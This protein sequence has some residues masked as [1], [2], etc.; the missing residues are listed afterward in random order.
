[1][2]EENTMMT[3]EGAAAEAAAEQAAKAAAGQSAEAAAEQAAEAAAG[4]PAAEAKEA[5]KADAPA[6]QTGAGQTA[7]LPGKF[8]SVDALV[9]AY[10]ALEA[11]FTR[12]S[13]RLRALEQ[14]KKAPPTE[15]PSPV[16]APCGAEQV[17]SEETV[18]N[19]PS[20]GR[21]AEKPFIPAKED[22]EEVRVP[23]MMHAG[24]GVTAPA[25]RPKNFEEAGRLALGYLK[26]ARKG[27]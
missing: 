9:Q 19:V 17:P 24:A 11:E 26:N 21:G 6:A 22:R 20:A 2:N 10:E 16:P 3:E 4:R 1:M 13:Q 15:E 25:V 5:E 23:L 14:A 12:R 7:A 18:M 27:E 8:K